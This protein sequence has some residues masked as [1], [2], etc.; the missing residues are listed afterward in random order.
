M[1]CAEGFT[2][3][4]YCPADPVLCKRLEEAGCATVMPLGSWIGSNQGVKTRPAIEII[5]EQATVPV[6]VDAGLGAPSHAAE[7]MEL[8]A[9]AVLVNTAIGTAADPAAM[10]GRSAWPSRPDGLAGS[11]AWH[12]LEPR[13]RRQSP[14]SGDVWSGFDVAPIELST[15]P[16]S[17]LPDTAAADLLADRCRSAARSRRARATDADVDRV[18]GARRRGRRRPRGAAVTGAAATTRRARRGSAHG[19]ACSA[20]VGW[21][22]CSRPL[23]L[24]NECVSVCTY[25]GFSAG[26]E[27]ARRTLDRRGSASRNRRAGPAR[28][29]PPA[30]R[31]RRARP[32]R[33]EG[34]T[35]SRWSPRSRRWCRSCRSRCRCGTSRLLPRPRRRRR[36][37]PRRVPG[38]LRP[39]TYAAVHLKGKKRNDVWRLG[40]HRTGAA[41]RGMRRL[42]IGALLGLHDDW[43][44]EA[45]SM[46]VHARG[47][48]PPVVAERG[49]RVAARGCVRRRAAS[50][51]ATRST[52]ASSCNSCAG[53]GCA[54]PTSASRC[55]PGSRQRCA[56]CS[57][58]SA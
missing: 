23:Y 15:R 41:R 16:T 44:A 51:R 29:A 45:L 1:S 38:D 32:H 26:N 34:R 47:A 52:T 30:A 43:R 12:P 20:S 25:C 49:Q 40:A 37:R 2:V 58:S 28:D 27:I 5:V 10:A 57:S 35:C 55:R 39:A 13:R 21:C 11:P 24:S 6:V 33:V 22:G 46:A 8:G 3:L 54:C 50:N 9:D 31:R 48:V 14:L 17:V 56:T 4:P 42:G 36:R 7:A 53:C 19:D 18:L